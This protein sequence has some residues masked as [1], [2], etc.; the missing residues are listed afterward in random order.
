MKSKPLQNGLLKEKL[1]SH[2]VEVILENRIIGKHLS[3]AK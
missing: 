3:L 1:A 2:I